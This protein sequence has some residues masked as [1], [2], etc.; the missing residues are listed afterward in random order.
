MT[1]YLITGISGFVGRHLLDCL[2]SVDPSAE[3]LGLDRPRDIP[4]KTERA[5]FRF[6]ALDMKNQNALET[7]IK[8][9]KPD[10]IVHLAAQSSVRESWN[11]PAECISS[12]ATIGANLFESVRKQSPDCRILFVGSA[13]VYAH[14][15]IALQEISP[16]NP[17]N[18]YA[19]SRLLQE[20]VCK[21]YVEEFGLDIVS[22]RS[23]LHIGPGQKPSFAIASFVAQLVEAQKNGKRQ[24]VLKTGN[25]DLQRDI[26]DVRDVVRA[27]FLLL[28]QGETGEIYNVCRGESCS[29]RNMIENIARLLKIEVAMEI[30]PTLLRRT[31]TKTVLGNNEKIRNRTDWTPNVSMEQT[32]RDMIAAAE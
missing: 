27:Y 21:F 26:S 13:E 32:L 3:I 11:N 6:E 17:K 19:L 10:R 25:V 31:D 23:F 16:V 24:T 5:P 9:F 22:T 14:Q 2:D 15:D 12:N 29:L 7:A 30:M 4:F 20:N 18:P 8:Q 28:E 1:R